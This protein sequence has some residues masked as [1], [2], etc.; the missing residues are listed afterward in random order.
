MKFPTSLIQVAEKSG[1]VAGT[2]V[3]LDPPLPPTLSLAKR[4]K[5]VSYTFPSR[6]MV[7]KHFR[8]VLYYLISIMHACI[9]NVMFMHAGFISIISGLC[10]LISINNLHYV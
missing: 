2:K 10:Y 6:A 5:N 3:V 7:N 1:W 8:N 9:R 4:F